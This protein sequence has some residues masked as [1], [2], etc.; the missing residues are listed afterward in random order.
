M[1]DERRLRLAPP[2]WRRLASAGGG[3]A[4]PVMHAPCG[5]VGSI[6]TSRRSLFDARE[7]AHAV[8]LSAAEF[9]LKPRAAAAAAPHPT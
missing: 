3:G 2:G 8:P 5:T 1:L 6:V 7:A 9:H 4:A